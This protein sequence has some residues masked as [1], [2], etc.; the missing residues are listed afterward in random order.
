MV[1]CDII[2]DNIDYVSC[3]NVDS[4]LNDTWGEAHSV[5]GESRVRE[6]DALPCRRSFTLGKES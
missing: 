3:C 6:E 4:L 2:S 1:I 5:I